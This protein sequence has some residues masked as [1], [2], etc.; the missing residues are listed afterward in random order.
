M[1]ASA[2]PRPRSVFW[3]SVFSVIS[4]VIA[5]VWSA[6]WSSGLPHDTYETYMFVGN[7]LVLPLYALLLV[8]TVGLFRGR[9]WGLTWMLRWALIATAF[10]I[11]QVIL[12]F[13]WIA[14]LATPHDLGLDKM[15]NQPGVSAADVKEELEDFAG[16]DYTQWIV[17]FTTSV[18]VLSMLSLSLW[19]L[20][21]LNRPTVR[22]FFQ[23]P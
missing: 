19:A 13:A 3:I 23:S 21:S 8:A 4:A 20:W 14:P 12:V 15:F 1:T 17:K 5:L 2:N 16:P 10:E 9:R 6:A 18:E 7:W 22:R 11:I